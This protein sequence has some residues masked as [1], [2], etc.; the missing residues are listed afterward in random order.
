[1]KAVLYRSTE[2]SS[3][4]TGENPEPGG[5]GSCDA[6]RLW[7]FSFVGLNAFFSQFNMKQGHS[8]ESE[9][10]QE[11]CRKNRSIELISRRV[12]G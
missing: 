3:I 12:G 8:P 9:D 5:C 2:N 10:G 4:V 7:E 1:M 11:N 6:G